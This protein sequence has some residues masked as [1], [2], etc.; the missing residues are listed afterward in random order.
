[1][2]KFLL[3]GA[4]AMLACAANAQSLTKVWEH[5]VDNGGNGDARFITLAPNGKVYMPNVSTHDVVAYDA[6]GKTVVANIKQAMID[7]GYSQEVVVDSTT[8]TTEIRAL[9]AGHGIASDDAGNI[10]VNTTFPNAGSATNWLVI[11]PDGQTIKALP[12][13]MPEGVA[14]ARVDQ[15]GNVVGDLLGEDGGYFFLPPNAST[16]AVFVDAFDAG[17]GLAGTGVAT[18]DFPWSCSTST[19]IY[20]TATY[21]EM[22]EME[23][24]EVAFI[25]RNRSYGFALGQLEAG[26]P[27]VVNPSNFGLQNGAEG[28]AFAKVGDKSYVI[29]SAKDEDYSNN[30]GDVFGVF[31]LDTA[32]ELARNPRTGIHNGDQWASYGARATEDGKI[33]IAAYWIATKT[34][35]LYEFDPNGAA[36][37]DE[38]AADNAAVEY[39][40]L[41]GVKVANPENGIFVKKQG[42]KATK[43]VL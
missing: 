41:Q 17:D 26:V 20:P 42:A 37:I 4:A 14:A 34:V 35:A 28:M 5:T 36:A 10:L 11:S 1:M 38:I 8:M 7:A 32:E 16:K 29:Q 15:V 23:N 39:Y 27:S 40:N 9:A 43:V 22:Y 21:D 2:K 12:V 33:L 19:I 6:N 13:E 25:A 24:P 18:P 31:D 30:R 3:L